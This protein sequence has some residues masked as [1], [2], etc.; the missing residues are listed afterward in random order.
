MANLKRLAMISVSAALIF[1]AGML[2]YCS[3]FDGKISLQ[4]NSNSEPDLAGYRVYYGTS[5]GHYT[6]SIMVGMAEQQQPG[7]TRYKLTGLS[8]DQ[9]YYIAVTAYNAYGYESVFS[10]EVEGIAR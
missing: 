10:N 7:V 1:T 2:W 5:P 3:I 6:N 9:K 4:W 8:K